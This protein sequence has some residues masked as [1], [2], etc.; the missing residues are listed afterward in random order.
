MPSR[1]LSI[2]MAPTVVFSSLTLA[3]RVMVCGDRASDLATYISSRAACQGRQVRFICADNHFDPYA[4]TRFAKRLKKRPE[5]ALRSIL[6]ARAFTA[7]QLVELVNRLDPA[8]ASQ[9]IT[10]ISGPCSLFFDEDIPVVD[11]ARLFYR[12]LWRVVELS[13]AGMTLML[14]Q[15]TVSGDARRAYF[16]TDLC[17]ASDVILKYD[18]VHTFTL[19][20]R[21]RKALARLKALERMMEE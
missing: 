13:E 5:D 7:Y 2:S 11:A 4:V 17:R 1:V 6:I 19:E 12:M 8:R 16:L 3:R 18:A 15:N 20:S 14:T 10:I 21:G 9:S